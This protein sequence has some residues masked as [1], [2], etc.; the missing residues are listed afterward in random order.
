MLQDRTVS[1]V[2]YSELLRKQWQS[3]QQF[4][5]L[6]PMN[7]SYIRKFI[8]DNHCLKQNLKSKYE[9]TRHILEFYNIISLQE[10]YEINILPKM[11]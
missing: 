2:K 6:Q 11:Y 4:H 1:I 8:S 5:I 7:S 3:V 10:A 9:G